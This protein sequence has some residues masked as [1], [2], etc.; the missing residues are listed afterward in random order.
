M[1]EY[2]LLVLMM[3]ALGAIASLCFK[4]ST[5]QG[6]AGFFARFLHPLV[7]I[8]GTLYFLASLVNIHVLRFLPYSVVL[9]L[10]SITYIWTMLI[11]AVFLHETISKMKVLGLVSILGGVLLISL[12]V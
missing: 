11:S 1:L 8:G 2:L 12:S 7:L 10:T 4:R 3:T 5:L 6:K 9:P